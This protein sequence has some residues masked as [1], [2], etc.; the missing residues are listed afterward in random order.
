MTVNQVGRPSKA[1]ERIPEILRATAEVVVRDGLAGVTFAKVAEV[2]GMQRTLVL[3]YFGSRDDLIGA[4]IEHAVGA[5]GT[6]IF[7][8]DPGLS[9]RERV[10]SLF[11]PG[12]YRTREDLVVWTELVALSARDEHV[13]RRLRE[14]WTELWLPELEALL[15]AHSPGASSDDVADTVYA[16]VC[17]FEA[18]WAFSIQDVVDERRRR[19]VERA[20]ALILDQLPPPAP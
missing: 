20:A 12:A 19:Q 2:A 6:E 8:R 9:L 14:L 13:R 11:A 16:L 17:L 7:R 1:G 10:L 4:F 15:A 18:H 5:M 3:H